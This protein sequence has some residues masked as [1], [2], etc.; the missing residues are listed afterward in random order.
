MAESVVLHRAPTRSNS[1]T[2]NRGENK[3]LFSE[4]VTAPSPCTMKVTRTSIHPLSAD[5][6]QGSCARCSCLGQQMSLAH[7]SGQ[8]LMPALPWLRE[9]LGSA[10]W[11]RLK[12]QGTKKL[13][14]DRHLPSGLPFPWPG[15]HIC[16]SCSPSVS[17][18]WNYFKFRC[19]QE[20]KAENVT[21]TCEQEFTSQKALG[22][23]CR[24]QI[25]DCCSQVKKD[26]K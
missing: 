24:V 26:K 10:V 1:S 8:C 3:C 25:T 2:H 11:E 12:A 19:F 22:N 5:I 7:L 23:W 15:L 6:F 20:W 4:F 21:E 9:E 14:Q 17:H 16:F 18:T 13:H